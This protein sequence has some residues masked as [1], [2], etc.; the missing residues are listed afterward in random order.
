LTGQHRANAR[1]HQRRNARHRALAL[2]LIEMHPHRS[3]HHNVELPAARDEMRELRQAVVQPLDCQLRMQRR[4]A[5]AQF[6]C[7]LDRDDAVADG[8]EAGGIATRAGSDVHDVAWLG[9]EKMTHGSVDIGERQAL[10][11][12]DERLRFRGIAFRAAHLHSAVERLVT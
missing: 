9:R 3:H 8:S 4:G 11:L 1:S 6:G 12:R 7:G 10:V 2:L 5:R